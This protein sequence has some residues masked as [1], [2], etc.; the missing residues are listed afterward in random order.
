M[1]VISL[2]LYKIKNNKNIYAD[3][4]IMP[5]FYQTPV[6]VLCDHFLLTVDGGW[7]SWS[8]WE[9]CMQDGTV[10]SA[11]GDRPDM[12]ACRTRRCD[13][14]RPTYGGLP[15]EGTKF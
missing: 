11:Y 15:C 8:K 4:Y 13:N 10:Q 12:C 5:G 7:S 3:K 6:H 14:P 1:C 2:K 9:S